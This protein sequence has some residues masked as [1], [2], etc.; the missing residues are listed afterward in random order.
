TSGLA[1]PVGDS[2]VFTLRYTATFAEDQL[3]FGNLLGYDTLRLKSGGCLNEPGQPMLPAHTLRIALPAGMTATGVR[4][5]E[6]QALQL[7]GQYSLFPAQPPRRVSDGAGA[8]DFVAPDP[9]IYESPEPYPAKLVELTHQT[10]LAGQGIA[11][12]RL[13]PVRYVPTEKTLTL[14]RS[15]EIVIEGVGGYE[16]GDYLPD[17]VSARGRAAYE[18]TIADMVVNPEAVELRTSGEPPPPSRGVGPGSY[19]YVII[20]TS[21]WVDDFQ[22]L[23]DWKTKKGTPANIVTTS[24]I[25]NSGGYSGSDQDKIRAF[26]Q[27]AHSTWGATYFLLG[28]DTDTVPCDSTTFSSIDPEAVP[29]DTYYADYDGD[30]TCEVHVGRAS[31]RSAS[32]V[33]TFIDKVFTY[34]KNPPLTDYAKTIAFFGFDL[35]EYTPGEDTKSDI[36]SLYIPSGWTYRSE[37]DSESGSHMSDVIGYMNQ[38]N[39]LQNLID[40]CNE[41]VMGVGYVNHGDLLSTSD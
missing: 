21:D 11:L 18:Q 40:H 8:A 17:Q 26:V 32:A 37:Y 28:G 1:A 4:V 20:T 10:D 13:Y 9:R 7:A 38:G 27:D 41:S 31:V 29:N 19:G 30:W 23:A 25:Y 5:A 3:V 34:E 15:I 24:W 2:Q 39:H 35:D 33:S 16:C 6:T 36:E 14:Y 12:I 22:P